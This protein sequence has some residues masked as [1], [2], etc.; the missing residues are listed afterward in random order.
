MNVRLAFLG[1]GAAIP[2]SRG[3]PCLALKADSDIYLFDV[4]EGCQARMF[5]AGLSPL[6][7]RSIFLTHA[8]GDHYFGLFGLLQTMNLSNRKEPLTIF[9]PRGL[10]L[11]IRDFLR[12]GLQ[13]G[14]E[15]EAVEVREG[16]V[17]EEG[18]G[19]EVEAFPVCHTIESVGYRVRAGSKVFVYTG[20]TRPC[21]AVAE[22]AKGASV[23]IH[24]ATF[25]SDNRE[26]AIK[27]GHSTSADAAIVAA[28]AQ[29]G[30]LVLTHISSRY[31]DDRTLFFDAYRYF[32]KVVVAQDYMW[33]IC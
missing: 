23:L 10:A 25:A 12:R 24:E 28:Q 1:T 9:A 26:E 21:D 19:L 15:A 18:R 31:R 2:I 7:V 4:G 32:K 22:R 13:G 16:K 6:K 17:Y 14:F 11:S 27:Q 3:L 33:L 5:R 8:H 20:D 29:P 30:M